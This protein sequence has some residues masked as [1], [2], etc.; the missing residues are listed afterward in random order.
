[1]YCH[2]LRGDE[3]TFEKA[4][5]HLLNMLVNRFPRVRKITATKLY[6]TLLIIT[7]L[8]SPHLDL[9]VSHQDEI[10]SILSDSDW[11]EDIEKLKPIKNQLRQLFLPSSIPSA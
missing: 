6:E 1:M 7:D 5:A 10:M 2:L 11:D 4:I 3:A 8:G 9:M